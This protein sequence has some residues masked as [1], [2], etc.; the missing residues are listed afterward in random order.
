MY[1]IFCQTEWMTDKK[2]KKKKPFSFTK[3]ALHDAIKQPTPSVS[4]SQQTSILDQTGSRDKW[5]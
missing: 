2:E 4:W 5:I 1:D 3:V